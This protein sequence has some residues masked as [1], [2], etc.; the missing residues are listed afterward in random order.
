MTTSLAYTATT[1][2]GVQLQFDFPLHELTGSGTQVASLLNEVLIALDGQIRKAGDV[3]DGDVLQALAMALAVRTRMVEESAGSVHRLSAEL[4][5][6][7][8]AAPGRRLPSRH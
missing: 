1:A 7:A 3:S 2:S 5:E 4:V 8:L 6:T